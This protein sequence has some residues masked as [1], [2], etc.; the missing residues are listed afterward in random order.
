M[1]LQTYKDFPSS[2]ALRGRYSLC[3][4]SGPPKETAN[5]AA[6]PHGNIR[7]IAAPKPAAA[8]GHQPITEA[9]LQA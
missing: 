1:V 3:V 9:G 6:Q 5:M 2:R 7:V 8:P 4:I